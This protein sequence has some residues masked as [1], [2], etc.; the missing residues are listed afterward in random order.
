MIH[1]MVS[2]ESYMWQSFPN[3]KSELPD[4]SLEGANHNLD[5][6]V[7]LDYYDLVFNFFSIL[8]QEINSKSTESADRKCDHN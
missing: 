7:H 5:L 6:D 1:K 8:G 4:E 3:S 2:V